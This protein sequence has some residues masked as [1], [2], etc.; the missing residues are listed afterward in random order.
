MLKEDSAGEEYRE[1]LRDLEE[2][3]K[4]AIARAESA[5]AAELS[6]E[7]LEEAYLDLRNGQEKDPKTEGAIGRDQYLS[8][9]DKA[10][11]AYDKSVE[12]SEERW[13]TVIGKYEANLDKLDAPRY[14]P[15][16]DAR[17]RE[18]L[19][20]LRDK[21][22]EGDNEESLAL[23]QSIIPNVNAVIEALTASLDWLDR[24]RQEVT[25]LLGEASRQDL[26]GQS[27]K[28][29][30]QAR[31]T[32]DSSLGHRSR[33]DMQSMEQDLFDARHYLR[34]ALRRSD[35]LD[36]G[37]LDALLY[38]V[39]RRLEA[40]SRQKVL[41][42]EGYEIEVTPWSG[43]PYLEEFPLADLGSDEPTGAVRRD[44]SA[45]REPQVSADFF[46]ENIPLPENIP[47][48]ETGS[49]AGA[50]T[51][52]QAGTTE[53]LSLSGHR[54]ESF[55]NISP[56]L[57][58]DGGLLLFETEWQ[59]HPVT[60]FRDPK[61][62]RAPATDAA[63]SLNAVNS[64]EGDP[65]G[66]LGESVESVEPEDTGIE[67]PT[68]REAEPQASPSKEKDSAIPSSAPP[69]EEAVREE[70]KR[71]DVP[72]QYVSD[73]ASL[74]RPGDLL[75]DAQLLLKQAVSSW[76]N[77]VQARNK[78]DLPKARHYLEESARLLD[79]YSVRYA[80][81]GY[82]T[83]RRLNPE[84]CLWRIAGY[85]DIYRDPYQWTRIYQRNRNIISNPSL[86]YPGQ[87]LVIPSPKDR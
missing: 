73:E 5:G 65:F 43:D 15:E 66:N 32:Y 41:D 57:E 63:E 81:L 74:N 52:T 37:Q 24:L 68:D 48:G 62:E 7:L 55:V 85:T 49:E 42:S 44:A 30:I 39:Q 67:E 47:A 34:E 72:Q 64:R 76:K 11:Q 78:G 77:A 27:A 6:P 56:D 31:E 35:A 40:A 51:E 3:A 28:L 54:Q 8:A 26:K 19:R 14:M 50:E 53:P 21:I 59:L 86:I 71:E 38:N 33:G 79:Q 17:S 60:Q 69:P 87:R 20:Q 75:S 2:R 4:G 70:E 82:Y 46:Q 22:E 18:L 10:N 84:D 45:L 83:V 13:L 25:G 1:Q 80:V 29:E 23:Y 9:I 58:S 61:V 16:Y 12:K 36:P